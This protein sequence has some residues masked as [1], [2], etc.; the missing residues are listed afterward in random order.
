MTP[1]WGLP[2]PAPTTPLW[3]WR[4]G[5]GD[6]TELGSSD[7]WA[8]CQPA[9]AGSPCGSCRSAAQRWGEVH[10]VHLASR[11]QKKLTVLQTPAW[12]HEQLSA[13]EELLF[14][15]AESL[16]G[17]WEVWAMSRFE[18]WRFHQEG[19]QSRHSH[20]DTGPQSQRPSLRASAPGC[21]LSRRTEFQDHR[22]V[23]FQKQGPRC[24]VLKPFHAQSSARLGRD[25]ISVQGSRVEWGG[26]WGSGGARLRPRDGE[27]AVL[28]V[29]HVFPRGLEMP[30]LGGVRAVC[31]SC[32][33]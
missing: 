32:F 19:D 28:R 16:P 30:F 9:G 21:S 5:S 24:L 2:L 33:L 10:P 23:L 17:T 14:S 18:A 29:K 26:A 31:L 3:E 6:R 8:L 25:S 15:P 4:L 11:K 1:P 13:G 20:H 27:G 22:E 7:P 12:G